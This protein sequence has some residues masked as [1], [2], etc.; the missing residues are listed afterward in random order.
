MQILFLISAVGEAKTLKILEVTVSW[1]SPFAT[2][3]PEL[4]RLFPLWRE[5]FFLRP[6][7]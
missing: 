6:L 3:F 7:L 2:R 4:V 5:C 1:R